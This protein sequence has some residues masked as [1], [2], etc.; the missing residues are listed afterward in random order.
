[1]ASRDGY[2]FFFFDFFFGPASFLEVLL[3]LLFFE[4]LKVF[5]LFLLLLLAV[6]VVVL[7]NRVVDPQT[8]FIAACFSRSRSLPPTSSYGF[9]SYQG[10]PGS[11][12]EKKEREYSNVF[13]PENP[14]WPLR[15]PGT[16]FRALQNRTSVWVGLVGWFSGSWVRLPDLTLLELV[17]VRL[18]SQGFSVCR[19]AGDHTAAEFRTG[20]N[21][22]EKNTNVGKLNFGCKYCYFLRAR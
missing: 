3:L 13:R 11:N 2:F 1:M 12:R 15:N 19:P 18:S 17:C 10:R 20:R 22:T 7:Q 5:C 9:D 8:Q 4:P 14:I 21:F 6:G 16:D